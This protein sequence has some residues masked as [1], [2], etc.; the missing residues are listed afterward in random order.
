V[1]RCART[2]TGRYAVAVV[3]A[4]VFLAL[5]A[6][7]FWTNGLLLTLTGAGRAWALRVLTVVD[8]AFGMAA[9]TA[10]RLH[11]VWNEAPLMYRVTVIGQYVPAPPVDWYAPV[12]A[13]GGLAVAAFMVAAA[14]ARPR[15]RHTPADPS[16]AA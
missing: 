15:D 4:G 12:L 7:P 6:A 10:E 9:A 5:L 14:R 8:P 2:L 3:A 11:F 16:A 1:V 13:Y